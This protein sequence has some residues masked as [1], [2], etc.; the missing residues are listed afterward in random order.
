MNVHTLSHV[1]N[2]LNVGVVVVIGAS[3]HL[4]ILVSESDVVCVGRQIFWRGHHSEL[5]G[6]LVA[7]RLVCPFPY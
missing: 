6:P 7:K 4:D 5:D 1:H 2:E 3:R